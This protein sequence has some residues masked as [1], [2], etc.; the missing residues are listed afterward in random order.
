MVRIGFTQVLMCRGFTDVIKHQAGI[1]QGT[2]IEKWPD[3]T[4]TRR[5]GGSIG[6]FKYDSQSTVN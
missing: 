6:I 5:E 4:K 1:L 2:Q 3:N